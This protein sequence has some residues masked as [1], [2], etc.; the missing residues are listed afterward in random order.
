MRLARPHENIF[1]ELCSRKTSGHLRKWVLGPSEMGVAL[2]QNGFWC[3][4]WLPFLGLPRKGSL[5]MDSA[6]VDGPIYFAPVEMNEALLGYAGTKTTHQLVRSG[7]FV[8]PKYIRDRIWLTLPG[9][10]N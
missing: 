2:L 6:H 8:H 1:V 7:A 10:N 3:S 9:G 5:D 4:S